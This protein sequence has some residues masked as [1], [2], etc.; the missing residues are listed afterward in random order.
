MSAKK[1]AAI[2]SINWRDLT[3][4]DATKVSAFYSA[5]VGWKIVS[6]DMGGYNDYCMN[7]PR[8]GETVA[9]ICHARGMNAD[10]PP[11]W[12]M[13]VTVKD[14]NASL[15]QCRKLGGKVVR[16]TRS[17]GESRYSVIRDPAGAHV[18]LFE[19]KRPKAKRRK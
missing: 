4:P 7:T 16:A 15:R 3:V 18:A 1:K 8:T 13:Y 14:L 2:G 9:G 17:F 10:L 19:V 5:V 12:L 11:Q 6:L